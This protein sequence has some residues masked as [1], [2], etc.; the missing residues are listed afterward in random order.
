TIVDTAERMGEGLISDDPERLFRWFATKGVVVLP[1][2][3]YEE[4]TGKGLVITA[5]D[6]KKQTLEADTIIVALPLLPDDN[7]LKSLKGKA[8]EVYQIGDAIKPA[9]MPDAIADGC[10]IAR[11][12]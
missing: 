12:I 1:Q 8:A 11:D 6:G 10:R 7:L 3:R 9:Y 5:R 2:I 4:I